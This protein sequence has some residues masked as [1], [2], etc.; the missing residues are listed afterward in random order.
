VQ[1][2]LLFDREQQQDSWWDQEN[3]PPVGAGSVGNDGG[4]VRNG[5]GHVRNAGGGG[6]PLHTPVN[7]VPLCHAELSK[8]IH[9]LDVLWTEYAV[10]VP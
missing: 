6:A 3:M 2:G 7:R 5:D 10:G 8:N 4:H 9:S 1:L